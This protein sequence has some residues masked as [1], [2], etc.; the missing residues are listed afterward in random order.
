MT[1]ILE[2]VFSV[3]NDERKT[4]KVITLAGVKLKVKRNIINDFRDKLTYIADKN[5]PLYKAKIKDGYLRLL[6][7]HRC[8]AKCDF[9]PHWKWSEAKLKQELSHEFLFEQC[10]PLYEKVKMVSF[11]GGEITIYKYGIE[12]G[13]FINK[14]Y[15]HITVVTESNGIMWNDGWQKNASEGLWSVNFSIN[16]S[17]EEIYHKSCWRADGWEIPYKKTQQNILSYI[18][19]LKEKGHSVFNPGI[20]MVV[21][22]DSA[23][24]VYNFVKYALKIKARKLSFFFDNQ[25][26]DLSG[27]NKTKNFK[28]PEIMLPALK[29]MMEIERVLAKKFCIYFRLWLPAEGI[30]EMQNEVDSIPIKELREKYKDLLELAKDRDMLKE[31]N[32]R[33]KIRKEHG[34]KVLNFDEDFNA[35]LRLIN[36]GGKQVCF[37]PWTLIDIMAS[38]K[39]SFCSWARGTTGLNYLY[40]KKGNI[41]W[42]KTLNSMPYVIYR[43][44][45][46]HE[47]FS[48]C[49]AICPM[50]SNANPIVPVHKYG[51]DRE[52]E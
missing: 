7:T 8:N 26:T 51:F 9:C 17:N 27:Q 34:K 33:N 5:N 32:E 44:K 29:T 52:V 6:L 38:G 20:S 37:A 21:N 11:C 14:Y 15:P 41:D 19:L 30:D 47:D 16:G 31:H 12:L 22:R 36:I 49:Q 45:H 40:N 50:N 2:K 23:C 24:D 28:Y 39:L 25:E 18:N 1:K 4:H 46:L 35:T 43:K 48:G 3:K 13:E 10:K 42:E